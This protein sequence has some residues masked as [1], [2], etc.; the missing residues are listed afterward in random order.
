VIAGPS[1]SIPCPGGSLDPLCGAVASAGSSLVG[2]GASDVLSAVSTW[3][4]N[5]ADWLLGQLGGAL[6]A[7]TSIDITAAWFHSH[8]QVMAGLAAVVVLPMLLCAVIQAVYR[9]SAAILVRSVL[10]QLPL[11][12]L[13]AA[14][15]VQLVQ[16]SLAATDAM[17]STVASGTGSNLDSALSGLATTLVNQAASG[18]QVPAFVVLLGGLL[19]AFGAFVLWVELLVRAAAVY[20]AVLFLPL[21]L[22][23]LVWPA[24]SH[25]CRRVIDT[26]AA[27]VLSKFVIVAIL[28]LAVGAQGS[29]TQQGFSAVLVGGALLLLAAFSPF[30][31][32]R[33]IP[34]FESGATQQLEGARQRVQHAF[35]GAP[36]SAASFALRAARA[37]T[38][39]PGEPGTGLQTQFEPPGLSGE[40]E[41]REVEQNETPDGRRAGSPRRA[42]APVGL[43]GG[44]GVAPTGA[45][46]MI[47]GDPESNAELAQH[48]DFLS[49]AVRD[50]RTSA[51]PPPI[52]SPERPEEPGTGTEAEEEDDT[53]P[54]TGSV[55]DLR[56]HYVI[57]RDEIGPVLHVPRPGKPIKRPP[58][59]PAGSR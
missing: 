51:A 48:L 5:G 42:S 20:V 19:V 26:L 25:W 14:V 4:V 50:G 17:G 53:V 6:N 44:G 56:R 27:L 47:Q 13:L 16:L 52:W 7:T 23:S 12:L 41:S 31:L 36:R 3:V 18:Q 15:A 10:V 34:A 55:I 28:S 21:G 59:D 38:F 54:W 45:V 24:V 46:P 49:S 2:S 39:D 30:T 32:L 8:Y 33:L 22:A 43:G 1:L 37:E 40:R 29:G 35:G 11:A 58:S 57:T 9:Q